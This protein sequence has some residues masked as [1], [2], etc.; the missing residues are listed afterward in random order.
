[1]SPSRSHTGP[2]KW[3]LGC[4]LGFDVSWDTVR[5]QEELSKEHDWG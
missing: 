5:K 2:A 4:V 1:M 3:Q